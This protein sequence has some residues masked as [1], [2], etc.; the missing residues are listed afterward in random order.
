MLPLT[1]IK[2]FH[3]TTT[4]FSYPYASHGSSGLSFRDLAVGLSTIANELS[5]IMR[6]I[7]LKP[8]LSLAIPLYCITNALKAKVDEKKPKQ[9][10]STLR[11]AQLVSG[12]GQT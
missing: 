3:E 12:L 4:V 9:R 6:Y 5:F 1:S 8:C 11:Q 10:Q 7:F 2:V